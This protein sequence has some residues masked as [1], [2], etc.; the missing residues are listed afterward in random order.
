M[1]CDCYVTDS[2]RD[3]SHALIFCLV[4]GSDCFGFSDSVNRYSMT[5]LYAGCCLSILS[6]ILCI[7]STLYVLN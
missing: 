5:G 4:T 1:L 3:L 7:T 6:K 2:N